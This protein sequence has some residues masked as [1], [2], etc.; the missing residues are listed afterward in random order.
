MARQMV[1]V[2]FLQAQNCT[3]HPFSWRHPESRSDFLSA[4]YYQ[5]IG[6]ILERGKFQ[7][8][9]FDDR[10]AMP[11][12]YGLDHKHTVENGIRCVKMDPQV[13]L[14]A[15]AAV[16][17]K[18]GLGATCSTTYY[19]PYHIARA[20]GTI[21]LMTNGRA[22]WNVVTSVNDGEAMNMGLEAGLDHDRRYDRAEEMLEVVLGHWDTWEDD[23]LI[24]DKNSMRFAVGDKVHRLDHVGKYFRSRGPLTVPRSAQGRPIIIQAGASDRGLDLGA[25]YADVIFGASSEV[26]SGK[27]VYADIKSRVSNFGRNPDHVSICIPVHTVVAETKTA[28]EDKMAVLQS[29]VREIDQLSLLA[30][31]LNLDLSSWDLDKDMTDEQISEISG[32]K[33][34]RDMVIRDTGKSNP[35]LRDF[36][37]HTPRGRPDGAFVGGPREI[38]DRL[39]E[40]FTER[41]CDGF[42]LAATH[43]P[44]SYADF[45]QYVVPELQRRGLFH[46]EYSGSTLRE[47]LGIP[48]PATR[49]S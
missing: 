26:E 17:E 16:T 6:R 14:M 28:A 24:V 11:D 4:D 1:M 10:L 31:G 35:S 37:K 23:A 2:G 3:L 5:E 43:V 33:G 49:H 15:I 47:N 40:L 29:L 32:F 42:V 46:K 41:V 8:A 27:A 30:E 7:M 20:F 44:G 12:R 36:L 18:I 21:D 45:V 19:E 13:V 9:F 25:R 34:I 22:G 48:W 39:E 38:A